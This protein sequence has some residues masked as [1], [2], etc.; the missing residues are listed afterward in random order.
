MTSIGWRLVDEH[1]NELGESV[2]TFESRAA[3]QEE[4]STVKEFGPEAWV[5]VAE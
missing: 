5:S 3:A 4:L 2:D 1:G